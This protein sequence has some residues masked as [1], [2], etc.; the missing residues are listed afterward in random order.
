LCLK[1]VSTLDKPFLACSL[2]NLPYKINSY[3]TCMLS[4]QDFAWSK[5]N[6][7]NSIMAASLDDN[8]RIPRHDISGC[9]LVL[10]FQ[11]GTCTLL[12]MYTI[13]CISSMLLFLWQKSSFL[14]SFTKYSGLVLV[15]QNEYHLFNFLKIATSYQYSNAQLGW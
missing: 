6:F 15:V 13:F 7:T 10:I 2:Y 5:R 1:V 11:L 8:F 9:V 3:P 12:V 4:L 14:A